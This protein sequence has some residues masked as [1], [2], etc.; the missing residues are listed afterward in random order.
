MHQR[1][2][3]IAGLIFILLFL[4]Y[5]S[6]IT[7]FWHSH[8]LGNITIVHSHPFSHNSTHSHSTAQYD[9]IKILSETAGFVSF[10]SF[11]LAKAFM[12]KKCSFRTK[13]TTKAL[14]FYSVVW[15]RRGPP[16]YFI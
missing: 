1:G 6:S 4:S 11:L 15:F 13:Q 14:Q 9:L 2:R 16:T 7:L 3:T 10:A 5:Y 8:Q 12:A